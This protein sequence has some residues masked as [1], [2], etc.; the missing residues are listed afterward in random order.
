MFHSDLAFTPAV[1]IRGISLYAEDVSH[2]EVDVEGTR[3]VSAQQAYLDLPESACAE[4][5]GRTA[6]H[7]DALGYT[8]EEQMRRCLA[9]PWAVTSRS[10]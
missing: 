8:A 2:S 3:F 1:P 9:K 10:A 6:N 7:L 4:L 5:E